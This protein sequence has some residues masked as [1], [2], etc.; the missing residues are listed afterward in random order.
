MKV[1]YLVEEIVL[2]SS[3]CSPDG[4]FPLESI[5][6]LSYHNP[7]TRPSSTLKRVMTKDPKSVKGTPITC[8]AILGCNLLTT[9]C[10]C[11]LS[12]GWS[13]TWTKFS[14]QREMK[15]EIDSLDP[16]LKASNSLLDISMPVLKVNCRINSYAKSSQ[17][18]RLKESNDAYQR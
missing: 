15:E 17:V 6:K 4:S 12:V 8:L 14:L 10:I 18:L 11:S 2:T 3:L 5:G 16:C 7:L 1:F 9:I 13:I